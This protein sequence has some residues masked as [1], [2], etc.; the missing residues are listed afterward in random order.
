MLI[1][2]DDCDAYGT[3]LDV[4]HEINNAMNDEWSTELVDR[5]YILGVKQVLLDHKLHKL[6]RGF[7]FQKLNPNIFQS[8]FEFSCSTAGFQGVAAGDRRKIT[9]MTV[10]S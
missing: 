3:S 2:T 4:L 8:K 1:H 5:S 7:C 10:E 9:K 6:S